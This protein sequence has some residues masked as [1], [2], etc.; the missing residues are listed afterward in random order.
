[1]IGQNIYSSS[2]STINNATTIALPELNPGTYV[3]KIINNL[4]NIST[5]KKLIIK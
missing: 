2:I 4:K 5:I 1:M 3:L